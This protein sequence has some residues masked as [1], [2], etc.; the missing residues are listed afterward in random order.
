MNPG[1]EVVH[2]VAPSLWS[3]G[4]LRKARQHGASRPVFSH[5]EYDV[6]S[7]HSSSHVA[8]FGLRYVWK[9]SSIIG[10]KKKN[11][12]LIVVLVSF[13]PPSCLLISD[14]VCLVISKRI[15]QPFQGT[16]N[17]LPSLIAP[18]RPSGAVLLGRLAER[19]PWGA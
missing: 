8:L 15:S 18:W 19:R 1:Y 3:H 10:R 12:L 4:P 17:S 13:F 6:F 16:H 14:D 2:L 5:C 7:N 9:F 11:I